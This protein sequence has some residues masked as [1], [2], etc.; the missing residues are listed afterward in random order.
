VTVLGL[1]LLALAAHLLGGTAALAAGRSPRLAAGFGVAGAAVG[2]GLG[3]A[4]A[5][6]TLLGGGAEAMRL[7]WRVPYGSFSIEIEPLS[8]VFLVP[9]CILGPLA[10][11]YGAG[12][13]KPHAPSGERGA[14][15][16]L[17]PSWFFFNLLLASIVLVLL[18]R[19]AVLF[20]VAWEVMTLASYFL[21]TFEDEK[22]SVRRAGWTYLVAA[23]A[24]TA[25][26][27]VFFLLLGR[28]SLDFDRLGAAGGAAPAS[29]G[30]CFLLALV[31]F[32]TKAGLVPLHIWLPEAHP[33][34][35]SHVSALLSA[36]V[37][38]TGIYGL[39][40]SLTFLGPPAP[41]WGWALAAAGA[42]SAFLGI[43]NALAQHDLKRL[44]AYSSVE[45]IGLVALALGLGLLGV[46]AGA[47][48]IAVLGFAGALLHVWNHAL[49]KGLLFLGA[50]A[51]LQAAGTKR[52]DLLGGLLRRLPWTGAAFLAGAAALCALPPFGPFASELLIYL[53]AF[54]GVWAWEG[55]A[56]VALAG[57][58][59]VL[60]L[61]GGLA[62]AAFAKAFGIGFLGEPRSE[63]AAR[64]REPGLAL[65]LP[66][67][68]LALGSLASG[69]LAPL[70]LRAVEPAVSA[71]TN[72]PAPAVDL[73]LARASTLL[74]NVAL[75][76]GAFLLIILAL[77]LLRRAL[78]GR[79]TVEETVTWDCGYLE[80][81]PRM[82]YTGS[83]FAEPLVHLFGLCLLRRRAVEAPQGHFPNAASF[84]SEPADACG[85]G[86]YRP[87]FRG[88]GWA[89]ARLRWLQHGR[90]Q[91]Y[92]LYIAL[93][94]LVLL[95]WKLG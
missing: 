82:Q 68:A 35:P 13:L 75:A 33:A 91:L 64:A 48:G 55:S 92:V 2:S 63:R 3:L 9:A 73:E 51:V 93:T 79:R 52:I 56:A 4:A 61:A 40:R 21:I 22:T 32:G 60:A 7:P 58:I 78:L 90:L 16:R 85:D 11:V 53:G 18:A 59:G 37:I 34:A 24:G 20:L 28:D 23:H 80:P 41:W 88:L 71:L 43:L 95:L 45:N 42:A 14:A 89:V 39:L 74:G 83:S 31:G 46:S 25:F 50:G 12:Y 10:A 77:S 15:N 87:V 66:L 67:A 70:L 26:L 44:L 19:N 29:A 69:L 72:L 94:L 86:L 5:A 49:A 62:A 17:G 76:G 47:A 8:A 38:K 27:L 84:A 54:R 57:L 6:R 65:R 1:L 36:V 30:A 81:A